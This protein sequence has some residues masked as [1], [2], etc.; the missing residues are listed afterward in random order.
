MEL[1]DDALCRDHVALHGFRLFDGGDD[2]L[3]AVIRDN[4]TMTSVSMSRT[5]SIGMR[6]MLDSWAA[7]LHT[8]ISGK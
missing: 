4:R 5:S 2:K 8:R 3:L 6:Q 7:L 1:V